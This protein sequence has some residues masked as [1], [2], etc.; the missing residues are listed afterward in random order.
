MPGWS[1]VERPCCR[2]RQRG[3]FLHRRRCHQGHFTSQLACRRPAQPDRCRRD[4]FAD[5]R[6][7]P[8]L[9]LASRSHRC[10]LCNLPDQFRARHQKHYCRK[11]DFS[12]GHSAAVSGSARPLASPGI[13]PL[14]RMGY[15]RLG[16]LRYCAGF[17]RYRD[18]TITCASTR[19]GKCTR[20]AK[21]RCL[22]RHRLRTP[23]VKQAPAGQFDGARIDR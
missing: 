21:R 9:V 18:V 13:D 2:H 6:R 19:A 15:P 14:G 20:R 8:F 7:S 12:A 3:T 1:S 11:C 23:L 16:R 22:G 5:A 17:F 4:R 10:R